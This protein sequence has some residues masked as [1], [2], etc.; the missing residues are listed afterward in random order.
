LKLNNTFFTDD[1]VIGELREE[2]LKFLDSNENENAT[3]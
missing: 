1:E 2:I 3:Y